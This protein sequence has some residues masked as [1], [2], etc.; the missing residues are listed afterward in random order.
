MGRLDEWC[1]IR[2]FDFEGVPGVQEREQTMLD[3]I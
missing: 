3:E 1:A 2:M